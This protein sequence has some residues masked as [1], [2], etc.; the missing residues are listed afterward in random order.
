[1]ETKKE[2]YM[3]KAVKISLIGN[4][5]LFLIKITALFL[6][7]SLA[8]ATDLG[9][10]FAGL[11]VS[12]FLFYVTRLASRPADFFHNYG[13]TKI[14]NVCEAIEGIVLIGIALAMSFQAA[15][16]LFHPK[17]VSMPWIGLFASAVGT[18]I[19][20]AGAYYIFKMARKS[21][22][23]AIYAEG[24]HYRLE[25]FI[26]FAITI[27]FVLSIA[28]RAGG[29]LKL[30]P[31]VDPLV[32]LLV[33]AIIVVPS[34]K[35]AKGAFLKL[36]DAS[37]EEAGKLD[38]IKHIAFHANRFCLFKDLKT[39]ISGRKRFIELR[40]ILPSVMSM[41]KG[42]GIASALEEDIKANIPE[43]EVTI[44]TE[45]CKEDCHLIKTDSGCPYL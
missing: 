17:S 18:A 15:A 21:S 9:I 42:H 31:Y 22:S 41:K 40:I 7:N 24:V 35:L 10:T 16:H 1:M 29:Q 45:S 38:V 25:G 14:E 4:V 27:S 34:I 12:V 43:S 26:S 36:L 3:I 37:I 28:M 30:E 8:I 2:I 39:R 33:S 32:T 20:F 13:Y 11:S 6:V 19:N 23:P 5:A 44:H